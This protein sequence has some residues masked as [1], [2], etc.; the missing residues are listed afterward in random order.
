VFLGLNLSAV[1]TPDS[2]QDNNVEANSAVKR[3]DTACSFRK[4]QINVA[5]RRHPTELEI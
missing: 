2:S 3:G 5:L 1:S 4:I